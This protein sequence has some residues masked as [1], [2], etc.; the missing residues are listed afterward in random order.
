MAERLNV[1]ARL[2]GSEVAAAV[3]VALTLGPYLIMTARFDS[4]ETATYLGIVGAV[5]CLVVAGSYW[6]VGFLTEP[7]RR[8]FVAEATAPAD[9][10]LAITARVTAL[11]L[12]IR[13]TTNVAVRYF[14]GASATALGMLLTGALPLDRTIDLWARAEISLLIPC[15][16]LFFV[17]ERTLRPVRQHMALRCRGLRGVS[18]EG[19]IHIGVITRLVVVVLLMMALPLAALTSLFA[20]TLT[21]RGVVADGSIWL[22]TAA[23]FVSAIVIGGAVAVL[24]AE[25]IADPLVRAAR[26]MREVG[27][28]NLSLRVDVLTSDETGTLSESFNQMVDQLQ[29]SEN[30]LREANRQI[31]ELNRDLENKVEARTREL[32]EVA[33]RNRVILQSIGDGVI[34]FDA[35]QRAAMANPAVRDVLGLAPEQVLGH[36]VDAI[37]GHGDTPAERDRSLA[38]LTG[39][40]ATRAEGE[41]RGSVVVKF[42]LGDRII[43]TNFAPIDAP[44]DPNSLGNLGGGLVAVFR[45]ITEME[46]LTQDLARAN[47]ELVQANRHKSEFLANM[48]HELRTPLNAIIGFSELLREQTFGALN[49]RQT[50]YVDNIHA[51]GQHLLQLINDILDLS[52]VEAGKLRVDREL[53]A[54]T[55][56]LREVQ[57]MMK[58]LADRRKL[59]LELRVDPDVSTICADEGKFRQILINLISNAIKFTESGRVG[60]RATLV[61]RRDPSGEVRRVV[62]ITVRDTGIGIKLED[63]GRLFQEFQQLDGSAT[64]RH[65]GTGLG[66][67]LSKRLV[68]IMDGE[69]AVESI[70]GKGSVFSFILPAGPEAV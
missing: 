17:C 43:S 61:E 22:A 9:P 29:S 69:M 5:F 14:L 16:F 6:S 13:F 18:D 11:N 63:M 31:L 68:E 44:T 41:A 51:S 20:G 4:D 23:V 52:K 62:R 60:I 27:S 21:E 39:L 38:I 46:Q 57:T 66:L 3:L 32:A 1:R 58:P 42:K 12:P 65:D 25:S 33:N 45:D 55:P 26:I 40:L 7:L 34:V 54:V 59:G 28:G 30:R 24:L 47:A 67:A 15:L 48:S 53:F 8:F 49:V 36:R 10:A 56:V 50:R 19:V 35:D 70:H 37:V 64:R 2:F